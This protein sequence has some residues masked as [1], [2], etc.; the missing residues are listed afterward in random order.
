[1]NI[2]CFLRLIFRGPLNQRDRGRLEL[3]RRLN[4]LFDHRRFITVLD[5]DMWLP[6]NSW[7]RHW[8]VKIVIYRLRLAKFFIILT[9][10]AKQ[11]YFDFNSIEI[12]VLRFALGS[13]IFYDAQQSVCC[14]VLCK[15]IK[16]DTVLDWPKLRLLLCCP[17]LTFAIF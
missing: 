3:I 6:Q 2:V 12:T 15:F 4:I 13:Y 11:V 7:R 10:W 9:E 14:L 16:A 5:W 1:M 17:F 8:F